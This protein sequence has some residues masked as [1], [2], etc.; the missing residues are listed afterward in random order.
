M[1]QPIEYMRHRARM[2]SIGVTPLTWLQFVRVT[3]KVQSIN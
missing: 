2:A 1:D 3:D